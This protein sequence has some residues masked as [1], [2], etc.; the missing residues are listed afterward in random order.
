ME[1]DHGGVGNV[2]PREV[3]E[4]AL[5]AERQLSVGIVAI[6]DALGD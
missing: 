1:D 2:A 4:V 3:E 5:L 6:G